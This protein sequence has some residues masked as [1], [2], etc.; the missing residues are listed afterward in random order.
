MRLVG[1]SRPTVGS[2]LASEFLLGS[3]RAWLVSYALTVD[4]PDFMWIWDGG[5]IGPNGMVAGVMSDEQDISIMVRP[6]IHGR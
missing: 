4:E 5:T 6:S 1:S 2:D 3:P